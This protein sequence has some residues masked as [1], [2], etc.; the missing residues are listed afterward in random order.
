MLP[1]PNQL[2]G[3]STVVRRVKNVLMKEFER[4]GLRGKRVQT[5]TLRPVCQGYLT[6]WMRNLLKDKEEMRYVAQVI[7]DDMAGSG[8]QIEKL[9]P[10]TTVFNNKCMRVSLRYR[11]EADE[12]IPGLAAK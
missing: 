4:Q 11:E 6:V 8:W 9:Y 7:N 2:P 5:I 10:S 3:N 12:R 1:K